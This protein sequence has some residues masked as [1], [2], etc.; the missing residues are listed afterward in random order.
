VLTAPKSVAE[1]EQNLE[2]L[3]SPKMPVQERSHWEQYGDVI[4]QH[5]RGEIDDFESLWP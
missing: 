3:E 1:L 4:Y 5:G 2:V